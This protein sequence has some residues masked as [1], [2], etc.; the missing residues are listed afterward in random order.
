MARVSF[1]GIAA[2][3]I[4]LML[5]S[6][7]ALA[8]LEVRMTRTGSAHFEFLSWNLFLAWIPLLVAMALLG[9]H[10]ANAPRLL[11]GACLTLWVLFLPNAPYIVTDYI[12]LARDSRVPLWFDVV[13]LGSFAVSGLMLGFASVYLVQVVASERMGRAAGWL[14]SISALTLS[15]VGIYIGRVLRLNSWDA[16]REPGEL[17]ALALARLEDPLGNALLLAIVATLATFLVFGYLALYGAGVVVTKGLRVGLG[18]GKR[19]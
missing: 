6:A 8:L 12:H 4:L 3:A 16:L 11:L 7:A 5:L 2:G 19:G 17:A 1:R 13:L 18:T 14:L 9:M 10:R 15:A